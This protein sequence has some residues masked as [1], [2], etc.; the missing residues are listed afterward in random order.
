MASLRL[1]AGCAAMIGLFAC[2]GGAEPTNGAVPAGPQPESGEAAGLDSAALPGIYVARLAQ[3]A[4]AQ[5]PGRGP[6]AMAARF[7]GRFGVQGNCL[8]FSLGERTY[9]PLFAGQTAVSV[10]RDRVRIGGG[11]H[12]FDAETLIVGGEIGGAGAAV[13]QTPRPAS[14]AGLPLLRVGGVS[15]PS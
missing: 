15:P 6:V 3:G 14:C 11:S 12:R 8:I 2:S 4:L 9:L 13:L 5:T 1:T 7:P 10:H